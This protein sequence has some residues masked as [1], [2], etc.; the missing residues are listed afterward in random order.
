MT[1]KMVS[2]SS[3]YV[4]R[5]ARRAPAAPH[6]VLGRPPD[7]D[8]HGHRE[9][10][11]PGGCRAGAPAGESAPLC[12][13]QHYGLAA[14]QNCWRSRSAL[15]LREG[16]SPNSITRRCTRIRRGADQLQSPALPRRLAARAARA[17][18]RAGPC[19]STRWWRATSCASPRRSRGSRAPLHR[20][21]ATRRRD[22]RSARRTRRR[23]RS[24]RAVG[25]Q[26]RAVADRGRADL[27][28]LDAAPT[29]TIGRR[30]GRGLRCGERR[31]ARTPTRGARPATAIQYRRRRR[32]GAARVPGRHRGDELG[33]VLQ[34]GALTDAELEIGE[35][36]A[37]DDREAAPPLASRRGRRRA[38]AAAMRRSRRRRPARRRRGVPR[39]GDTDAERAGLHARL[40]QALPEGVRYLQA[41][42]AA[43]RLRR[44]ARRLVSTYGHP[45]RRS[46][47]RNVAG[48]GAS[49]GATSRRPTSR[50]R[51]RRP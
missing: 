38:A 3:S 4:G 35:A 37:A 12:Q 2:C 15:A 32:R 31:A 48:L 43:D 9:L 14:A 39:A 17:G 33:Q 23:S 18:R 27:R 51:R 16:C 13:Y 40:A 24:S 30:G 11:D 26:R 7:L 46:D 50:S 25:A 8:G 22:G 6:A 45:G 5:R 20:R 42:R 29:P 34:A 44:A 28:A 47:H 1:K 49:P 41:G 19:G 36:G 21:D 10:R